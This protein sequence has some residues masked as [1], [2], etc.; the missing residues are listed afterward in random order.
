MNY[1]L[2]FA[3]LITSSLLLSVAVPS[4]L[5]TGETVISQAFA[6]TPTPENRKAEAD[7]LFQEGVQQ[8]R[9][10]EYPKA[11]Q[12]YNR[13]LEMRRQLGDKAGVGQTLN[14]IGQVYN[15]LVQQEKALEVLQQALTIRREIKD[16]VG[17]GET[18]DNIGGVYLALFKDE[19]ALK[20]LQQ[21]LEIRREVKDKAG[22][23][24]TLSKLGFTYIFLKQQDKGL[25]LLQEALAI[26]KEVGDKFQEGLTLFRIGAAYNNIDDYPNSLE[27]FNKAL[28]VNREVGNRTGEGSSL[29]QIGFVYFKQKQYV[30]ALKFWQQ[31]LP[32]IQVA[33]IRDFEATILT[34]IGDTYFNQKQYDKA[35]EFYQQALPIVREVKKRSQEASVLASIGDSYF[36]QKQYDQANK[37]YQQ[38]LLIAQEVKSKS[39]EADILKVM[40]NIYYN[41]KQYDRA[42]KFYQQAL[43]IA[44]QVKNKSLEADILAMIGVI[45]FEQKQ[46]DQVIKFYQEALPV[47]REAKN[48]LQEANILTATGDVYFIQKQY[49]QAIIFYQQALALQR[50]PLNNR[51]AQLTILTQIMRAYNLSSIFATEQKDYSRATNQA[52]QVIILAPEA[53]NISRELKQPEVEKQ[54]LEIQSNA[55]IWI[56]NGYIELGDL[57]KA[58]EFAEQGL[59]IAHQSHNLTAQDIAVSVLSSISDAQGKYINKIELNQKKLEISRKLQNP[60]SET[61]ALGEI[62]GSYIILGDYQK[63]MEFA[64]QALTKI[65]TINIANLPENI[66]ANARQTKSL[67]YWLFSIC[68]NWIGEYDKALQ[69]AQKRFDFVNTSNNPKLKAEALIG[70][71]NVYTQ[72]QELETAINFLQQALAI[73][74]QSQNSRIE[75]EALKQLAQVYTANGNYNKATEIANLVLKIA[76][77]N[78]NIHLKLDSLIIL[79]DIYIAQGNYQ[80]AL[81]LLKQSLTTAKQNKNPMSEYNSL[82]YL[83]AFY[84]E[85]GEYKQGIEFSQQALATSQRMKNSQVEG[86][87]L[88]L[89]GYVSFLKGE[90]QE[91]IRF[92]QQGLAISQKSK[93]IGQEMIANVVL[94]LGYG[95]LNNDQKAMEAAQTFLAITR[96]SQSPKYEKIAL[97]LLGNIHRKSGRTQEAIQ[98]YNQALVIKISA[99]T[100]GENSGIYAGLARIYRDLNQPNVAIAYY[101]DAINSI[102][103]VRR[104]VKG[105][106]PEIQKS[107]LNATVDF[108]RVK[109]ADVYK[110]LADLLIKQGQE[111][112][113]Q[114]RKD[115]AQ[116]RYAQAQQ[117]M[118]LIKIQEVKDFARNITGKPQL[119]LA[120]VEKQIQTGNQTVIALAGK[121]RECERTKCQQLS[122]LNDQLTALLQETNRKLKEIDKE[123]GDRLSKDP[124]AFRPNSPKP[125]EVVKAQSNTIMIYPFVREEKLW[126]LTYFDKGRM[127]IEVPVTRKELDNQVKEFRKLMEECEKR[128]C[129]SAEIAKIK[130][131]S[132]QLNTWL[133]KPLESELKT[134]KVKNLVFALDSAIRYIPMSALFNGERYLIENYT[135]YNVFSSDLT[136]TTDKF[137]LNA[138]VLAMG[139]SDAAP[140]KFG[141]LPNVPQELNAIAKTNTRDKG[142]YSRPFLNNNFTFLTLRDN[143]AGHNILHLA[144]HGEF[145]PGKKDAS[146]ILSGKEE[147]SILKIAT[148][149]LSEIH[150]VVLSACQTALASSLHDGVEIGSLAYH[151]LNSGAKSVIASLWQVADQSTAETMQTFYKYMRT[152][153][154]PITKAEAL[155]MA[156]LSLLYSKEVTLE[157]IKRGGGIIPEGIPGKPTKNQTSRTTYA[158]PYYWAPFI[159]IGNGL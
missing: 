123:I 149:G 60:V 131:V 88:L 157:D 11:L 146:Y 8:Y 53:L 156:Q 159:L 69:F 118:D 91:T 136:N 29:M 61:L 15:G 133:I 75:T 102:E 100:V 113:A 99:K 93:L 106:T 78:K 44:R 96:K 147:I 59:K 9:R 57:Q 129:G 83:A 32:F 117:V 77:T 128:I 47:V 50:Q 19:E 71:A 43:P 98:A 109:T 13:V 62:S 66:Q 92:A 132:Q 112:E 68:Y 86:T 134:N 24:V 114:G 25:K 26:H 37:Y 81:E 74:K 70:L 108:N 67:I 56:G 144:T 63:G 85:L 52:N 122:Q 130:P 30:S 33:G 28:V 127:V 12:T 38:A 115:D 35:I 18:L 153:R 5:K 65:E 21:A 55:Y 148:L 36:Y 79:K 23:A 139:L 6:Q 20:T 58:Q 143:L 111:A 41:Q 73:G 110:E 34:S 7:K 39:L 120:N 31:A 27:W 107:F 17:E 104:G 89:L 158:H 72:Q 119:P 137:P 4:L 141:S 105:L 95:D 90:P 87:S 45:Y 82:A 142:I 145:V 10:G 54:V 3:V 138:S 84:I 116:V 154:Q 94:S 103:E 135:I 101:K 46:Y 124:S 51:P 1:R 126:L 42:I 14:N 40:G 152:S 48:Q 140:P 155:R 97:T 151:F 49:D 2:K 150:L 121:I 22:E 80:K 16:R 64:Q 125:Q 76:D